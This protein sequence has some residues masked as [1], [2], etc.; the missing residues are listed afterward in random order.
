MTCR[1]GPLDF[2]CFFDVFL[3]VIFVNRGGEFVVQLTN[4][5]GFEFGPVRK[6]HEKCDEQVGCGR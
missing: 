6:R 2:V 3:S 4:I 1:E 5:E